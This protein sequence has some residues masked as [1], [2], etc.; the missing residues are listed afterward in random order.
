MSPQHLQTPTFPQVVLWEH[1]APLFAEVA[2]L[3]SELAQLK[4]LSAEWV[5][6][7]EALRITGI[8]SGDT[9]KRLRELC[10]SPIIVRVEGKTAKQPKYSRTSLVA[11]CESK[12]LQP[13]RPGRNLAA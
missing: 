2:Q 7:K 12:I 1:V 10:D 9:L 3:K 4:R 11:Y 5:D 8:K 13:T 6:T